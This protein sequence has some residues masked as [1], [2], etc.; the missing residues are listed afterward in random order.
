MFILFTYLK[1]P[2][3]LTR[4]K[5]I[6]L[7]LGCIGFLSVG[8][9]YDRQIR[10][11]DQYGELNTFLETRMKALHGERTR[12]EESLQEAIDKGLRVQTDI[13]NR[14]E[15]DKKNIAVW[16]DTASVDRH[17]DFFKKRIG[18]IRQYKTGKNR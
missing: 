8:F 17:T 5:L 10:K 9:L 6:L 3:T 16:A 18:A 1:K 2:V 11:T 7:G 14:Y 15:K 4:W 12:L 13:E